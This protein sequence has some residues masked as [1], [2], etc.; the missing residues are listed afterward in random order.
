M[1]NPILLVLH[2]CFTL[3]AMFGR[4]AIVRGPSDQ[5]DRMIFFEKN[6]QKYNP[7]HFFV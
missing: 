1:Q 3:L 5:G 6:V 2:F 7:A 4:G